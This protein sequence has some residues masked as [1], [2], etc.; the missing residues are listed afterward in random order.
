MAA[1]NNIDNLGSGLSDFTLKG[2]DGKF[3]TA[4]D[5]KNAEVLIIIFMCNHCPYVIAVIDRLTGFQEKFKSKKVLLAGINSNDP[6]SYPED[7]FENMKLFS[8]KHK[9]NFPYLFDE[10][11]E[12]ARKYQAV[13]TPDIFVYDKK[14]VLKYRGRFDDNWKD[15]K[16]VKERDLEKAVMLLLEG[17]E[18]NF[19]QIPSMGCSIKWKA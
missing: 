15:E 6:V 10:T 12:T 18:I 5:F 8:S 19:A 17:K 7:S 13:C 9:M 14:R 1:T 4:D 16:S 2:V 3:Y 11:Q